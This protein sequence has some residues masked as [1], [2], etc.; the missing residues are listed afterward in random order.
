MKVLCLTNLYPIPER[1]AWGTFVRSQMESL[2]PLGVDFDVLLVRGWEDRANYWRQR[3]EVRAALARGYEL[4]HVH[5][6]L[7][8]VLLEGMRTPPTVLSLCG[9][10][11]LGRARPDGSIALSSLPMV[12]LSKRAARRAEA[13]VVKSAHMRRVLAPV[14]DSVVLPNGVNFDV[15][16]PCPRE[17]ARRRLGWDLEDRY[18][19]FAADPAIAAKN[20]P[21][22]ESAMRLLTAQ[23]VH[24]TL[25]PVHDRPQAA[26][27]DAMNAADAL[28]FTSWREGSPNVVKEAMSVGLPVVSVDVG[29]VR[30]HVEGCDGC[31]VTE[32]ATAPLAAA[33]RPLLEGP[34]RTAGRERV[35]YLRNERVAERLLDVYRGAIEARAGR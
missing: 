27:V 32:R 30:E 7:T 1:P 12:W 24:A 25:V 33:L 10:D 20:F 16:A 23:G 6:G 34:R 11:L 29:D 13:V 15:F 26:L 4:V 31:A 8:G 28:L 5:F 22:A 14:R 3:G 17:A 35:A 2:R 19:L 18:V 21:L 9:D